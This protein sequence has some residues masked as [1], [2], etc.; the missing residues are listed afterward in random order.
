LG[1]FTWEIK[2]TGDGSTVS[3]PIFIMSESFL[4]DHR[5]RRQRVHKTPNTVAA[6]EINYSKLA[7]KFT[8]TL[9]KDMIFTGTRDIIKKIGDFV[10]RMYEFEIA[11]SFGTLKCKERKV[12]FD[13]NQNRLIQVTQALRSSPRL[14]LLL[15]LLFALSAHEHL[16]RHQPFIFLSLTSTHAYF[17]YPQHQQNRYCRKTCA[18]G[19]FLKARGSQVLRWTRI[20]PKT[21]LSPLL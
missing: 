17:S 5:V 6:E 18:W 7:I 1:S 9:T 8:K 16:Y 19:H 4:K 11:F 12:R 10:D 15:L 13:F 21:S 14:L 3:R 20:L 2:Y